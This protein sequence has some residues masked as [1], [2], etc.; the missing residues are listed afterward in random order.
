MELGVSGP[1]RA[2][3]RSPLA[4]TGGSTD[5]CRLRG[6]LRLWDWAEVAS[7]WQKAALEV[8]PGKAR[9]DLTTVNFQPIR[10]S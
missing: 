7:V 4:S 1:I 10:I 9:L 5:H 6:R 3:N 2:G 8:E